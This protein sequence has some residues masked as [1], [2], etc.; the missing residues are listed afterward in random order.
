MVCPV[1]LDARSASVAIRAGI[2]T[3]EELPYLDN[4]GEPVI[5]A[6]VPGLDAEFARAERV[7]E[8]LCTALAQTVDQLPNSVACEQVPLIVS[9]SEPGRPGG[10][11][12]L[13]RS[14][15]GLLEQKLD[16]S[17]HPSYSGAVAKGHTAGYRA[18]RA[19]RRMLQDGEV[20]ACVV[21]GADS[22][23]NASTLNWLDGQLRL[24]KRENSDGVIPGE[25]AGAFL[26]SGKS[27][28]DSIAQITGLGFA[29]EQ[30]TVLTDEPMLGIGLAAAQRV[31]LAEAGTQMHEIAVRVADCSGESYGFREQ[32]LALARVMRVRRE[33][34]P[35]WH[36]TDS[37]GESGA[38]GSVAQLV[39]AALALRDGHVPGQRLIS[40][41][42]AVGGERS[43]AVLEN[44][45]G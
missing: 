38:G 40:S 13:S 23:I 4:N 42:S 45:Y 43:V 17:F 3:F 14:V 32:S 39:Y 33:E 34:H 18:L 29:D 37:I 10:C 7:V 2:A 30:A 1:G 12:H 22:F 24:K 44:C 5:G 6:M 28:A 8:L 11:A 16:V 19:A 41:G 36:C 27:S 31:A 15:V 26:V 20:P 25:S 9:L 35:I 21:C